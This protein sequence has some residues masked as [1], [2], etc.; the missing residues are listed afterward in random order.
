MDQLIWNIAIVIVVSIVVSGAFAWV[1]SARREVPASE[2]GLREYIRQLEGERT[3]LK[4]TVK[5]L[6]EDIRFREKERELLRE[7]R[8]NLNFKVALLELQVSDLTRDLDER[9]VARAAGI[10]ASGSTL[11]IGQDAVGGNKS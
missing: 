1:Q 4:A 8:Q 9:R 6:Q 2:Q 5:A 7:E 11:N 3:E 10:S